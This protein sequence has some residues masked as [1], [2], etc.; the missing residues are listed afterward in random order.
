MRIP[1]KTAAIVKSKMLFLV[2]ASTAFLAIDANAQ[3]TTYSVSL[4]LKPTNWSESITI[5]QFNTASGALATI[6]ITMV[7]TI[8]GS[9]EVE[10]LDASATNVISTLSALMTIRR[11]DSTVMMTFTPNVDSNDTFGAYDGITDY[12]GNSGNTHYLTSTSTGTHSLTSISADDAGFFQGNGTVTLP[13]TAEG[14]SNFIGAGNLESIANLA[15][16]AKIT[17]AYTRE[18]PNLKL[19]IQTDGDFIIGNEEEIHLTVENIGTGPTIDDITVTGTL[20]SGIIPLSST[21][22]GWNCSVLGQEITCT[23]SATLKKNSSLPSITIVA[24]VNTNAFPGVSF[25]A[26][27]ST[28][29]DSSSAN[30]TDA[31][32]ITVTEAPDDPDEGGGDG[33]SGDG[34]GGGGGGGSE[35]GDGG[36]GGGGNSGGGGG[37]SGGGGGNGGGG[38]GGSGGRG[39]SGFS[40]SQGAYGGAKP[41]TGS[42]ETVDAQ[43]CII[44]S[45]LAEPK[46]TTDIS[47]CFEFVPD[48]AIRFTDTDHHPQNRF[49]ESLKKTKIVSSGD[50]IVS[51]VGAGKSGVPESG[52]FPFE[53]GRGATRFEVVKMALISNCIPVE[54]APEIEI[55]FK[56]VSKEIQS[57]AEKYVSRVIYTAAKNGI[58]KGYADGLFRP[59][60]FASNAETL[61][62][63]L[64][65]S[66][67]M[68]E[69]FELQSAKNW[70]D[71]YLNFAEAN[72][73]IGENF[74]PTGSMT[75]GDLSAL[76]V[77][78]MS[79]N[80]DPE[81]SG[82]AMRIDAQNQKFMPAE[83]FFTPIGAV[84]NLRPKEKL[85]C[86]Q[87][88]NWINSCMAYDGERRVDF[89][90]VNSGHWSYKYATALKNTKLVPD[91]DYIFSGVGN[92]STGKQQEKFKAGTWGFAPEFPASRLEVVK[93]ALISNC[94]PIPDYIPRTGNV[95][96]DIQKE[97]QNDELA[98][99]TARVFYTASLYGIITGYEDGSA[100]PYEKASRI[101]S[102]AIL[103]RAANAIPK[104]YEAK[105]SSFEDAPSGEWYDKYISFAVNNAIAS[106]R[107]SGKFS[108]NDP[109]LRSELSAMLVRIMKLSPDIRIRTYRT[110]IDAIIR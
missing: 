30:N 38:G 100:K 41:G 59:H 37:S 73:L 67:A 9:I 103:L 16:S 86:D 49:I 22:A 77:N 110:S 25:S 14:V 46:K 53:P 19:N 11:P 33:E 68:P 15:A 26:E 39:S 13:V 69:G 87:K 4:P 17:F 84:G 72:R 74:D 56:D 94:I 105:P 66:G 64:R 97:A 95:F 48:R 24:G 106:G 2:I 51:G 55:E 88:D 75:R 12:E 28:S 52:E 99:F 8:S 40:S 107:T 7:S 18:M 98:D 31:I 47:L 27:V 70:F 108:P 6:D 34:G 92:H 58:A 104:D 32:N 79:L 65:A 82:Y 45:S 10:N 3:T 90:D 21:G 35:S 5:P 91:G 54:N 89:S 62:L 23:S 71:P 83:F 20:P 43:G 109:L 42:N 81:I 78:I 61:A 101:E 63:L 96:T 102:L 57:E 76:I 80:P 85:S 29:D 93:T 36:G 50:F 44:S 60:I 1:R